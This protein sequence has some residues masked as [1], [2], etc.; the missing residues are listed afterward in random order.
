MVLTDRD[1]ALLGYLAVARYV[2]GAQAHRLLAPDADKAV[3]SR[4]L[5]RMCEDGSG[6]DGD[7]YLKRL[8]YQRANSLPFPVWT[9]TPH[10]RDVAGPFAPGPV[11]PFLATAAIGF[12]LRVLAVNE[13]L[14]ALVL[15]ARR[16]PASPL[17]D[18]PFRWRGVSDPLRFQVRDLLHPARAAVLRPAAILDLPRER[19]RIFV[20]PE[21]G[22]ATLSPADPRRKRVIRRLERYGT[23]FFGSPTTDPRGT[24]YSAAFPDGYVPE[25]LLLSTSEARRAQVEASV[26]EH[27]RN[28]EPRFTAGAFTLGGAIATFAPR[29]TPATSAAPRSPNPA[30]APATA[31]PH[32]ARPP[33]R[34]VFIDN[35]L[36]SRLRSGLRL[37]VE[38]FRSM[39]KQAF[40]HSE[41]CPTRFALAAAPT[42]ELNAFYRL[43]NEVVLSPPPAAAVEE[44]P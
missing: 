2:T 20:E 1:R 22:V 24:W 9:L 13:L 33:G 44:R 43:L 30:P 37:Y 38:T 29:V 18:L 16:S 11:G 21:L 4:R 41:T 26:R 6:P 35:A 12:V 42:D 7:A 23:Y 36:A 40:V 10:G 19:R 39:R 28:R 31:A 32:P 25:V 5:S 27:F 34:T 3:T 17:V 15:A 8:A 14:L